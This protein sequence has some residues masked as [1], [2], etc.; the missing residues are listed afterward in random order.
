MSL[1]FHQ[2]A[3]LGNCDGPFFTPEAAALTLL[4]DQV[5]ALTSM[6]LQDLAVAIYPKTNDFN[7]FK[8]FDTV[9]TSDSYS[10]YYGLVYGVHTY[11][12]LIM[13]IP[14]YRDETM[15]DGTHADRCIAFYTV[16]TS[17]DTVETFGIRAVAQ[18]AQALE[19][20]LGIMIPVRSPLPR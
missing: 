6:V 9:R 17:E 14:F 16:D 12:T 19:R 13:A 1:K 7:K 15:A 3:T 20:H 18:V 2:G 11:G 10:W 4:L 8:E 5:P